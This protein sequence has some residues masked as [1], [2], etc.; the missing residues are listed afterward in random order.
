VPTGALYAVF[1]RLRRTAA[2]I[3]VVGAVAGATADVAGRGHLR[4]A[5]WWAPGARSA[6]LTEVNC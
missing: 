4:V 1:G 3:L 5:A 6:L 2:V